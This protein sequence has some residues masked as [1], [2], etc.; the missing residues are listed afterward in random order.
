[1]TQP[2]TRDELKQGIH[3]EIRGISA[4]MLQRAMENN[5]HVGKEA[6]YRTSYSDNDHS[7]FKKEGCKG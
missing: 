7:T 6:I 4:G 1:M 3:D 5:A 2:R